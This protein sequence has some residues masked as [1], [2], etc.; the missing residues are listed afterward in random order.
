[1]NDSFIFATFEN[2]L[3]FANVASTNKLVS[4][5]LLVENSNRKTISSKS[6]FEFEE[7]RKHWNG[8]SVCELV[9]QQR[10]QRSV[11]LVDNDRAEQTTIGKCYDFIVWIH[12]GEFILQNQEEFLVSAYS[13]LNQCTQYTLQLGKCLFEKRSSIQSPEFVRSYQT[14]QKSV[15]KSFHRFKNV[16]LIIIIKLQFS[17]MNYM[18]IILKRKETF[19]KASGLQ[20]LIDVLHWMSIHDF[21][22]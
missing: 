9:E 15:R 17:W 19:M 10:I 16:F 1:V 12:T 21:L 14:L 22:L 13:W 20:G 5:Q 11:E 18:N 3:Y 8:K 2:L 7:F 6:L 4:K